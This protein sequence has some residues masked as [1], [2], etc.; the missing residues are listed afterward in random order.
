MTMGTLDYATFRHS[1]VFL[2]IVLAVLA[3]S[4]ALLAQETKT[5]PPAES[6][7][8]DS[9]IDVRT[10][11]PPPP[12]APGAAKPSEVKPSHIIDPQ[13]LREWKGLL[14][15]VPGALPTPPE[16]IEDTGPRQT[17]K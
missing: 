16:F 14:Q 10:L 1:L 6:V 2:V 11:L 17:N 13:M 12:S 4:G 8:L 9:T 7:P 15:Q 3:P 5:L